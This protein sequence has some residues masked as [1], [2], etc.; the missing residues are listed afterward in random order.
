MAN[1][2]DDEITVAL[3]A[4]ATQLQEGMAQAS[5]SITNMQATVASEAA[6][7]NAAVQT[8]IDA[9]VRLNAAFSSNVAS[10]EGIAEAEAALDQAMNAGAITAGEYASYV[11]TLDAAE[12]ALTTTAQAASAALVEQNAAM[13]ISG[14]VARELGVMIGELARGNYTRLEGST[15]TLANRTGLL[16]TALNAV[17]SPLGLVA[18]AAAAVGYSIFEAGEDFEKMEGTVLATGEAAGFTAGQL[19]GIAD[20]IGES[21]G[22]ISNA[23][24][25]VQKLALSGRFAGQD[26]Q[27]VATAAADMSQLTGESIQSCITQIE[28]L[29]EDPLKA[30]A[31]LNDQ[32]HFLTVAQFEQMESLAQS[33]DIMGAA[34]IAYAAMADKMQGRSDEA[35]QHVNILVKSLRELKTVWAEDMQELDHALGGG[36]D[37]YGLNEAKQLLATLKEQQKYAEET[38]SSALPGITAQ[39]QRQQ[40]IVDQLT[41]GFQGQAN[42]AKEVGKAAQDSANKIDEMLKN[43][44]ETREDSEA[45]QADRERYEQMEID[46][47][48]SLQQEKDYWTQIKN[49]AKEGSAEYRQAL[50]QLVE[51]HRKEGQ[52]AKEAARQS[53]E[54][55][56]QASAATM[57]DLEVQRE[58]TQTA[59]QARIQIDE[60]IVQNAE[61]LYGEDSAQYKRAVAEKISDTKSFAAA[62]I[63]EAKKAQEFI[64]SVYKAQTDTAIKAVDEIYASRQ[65]EV[66]SELTLGQI[67]AA[68]QAE[69]LREY[70]NQEY[71]TD[72][73]ILEHYRDLMADKPDIVQKINDQIVALQLKRAATMQE[74]DQK[75]A[76]DA[77]ESWEQSLRPI[78]Q[79]FDQSITGMI[80]GTQ[81][82]H[83]AWDRM[84]ESM[85]MSEIR[86]GAQTLTH[87]ISTE[88]AKTSA[89]V[90]GAEA[91]TSAQAAAAHEG[92]ATEAATQQQEIMNAAS[93]AAAKAYQAVV[94]IPIVGPVLAPVAA[95]GAFAAVEAYD[96]ISSAS[97]G[98]DRVPFDDAPA[99]L[100]RNEMVLPAHLA[101]RVRGMTDGSGGGGGDTHQWNIS[102]TDA[103]SFRQMML[104]DPHGFAKAA[105]RAVSKTR[106]RR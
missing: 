29:Q 46:R 71:Q 73:D 97:G 31:K 102:A 91:R 33:G 6:A 106:R 22:S 63:E 65:K 25:A 93:T 87:W 40:Q 85:L 27:L 66:Q 96:T 84:L 89:T 77:Q 5:A 37:A 95:A 78:M 49:E 26:L 75:A 34:S 62:Q 68:Q 4:N 1:S 11:A 83:Q 101:D 8:K 104:S 81:T 24:E 51:V 52:A 50:E 53:V 21:T 79:A 38:G 35:N 70:A 32:F 98:W 105:Q 56:K 12:A 30:V 72:L 9:M 88:L 17:L 23:T 42:A 67:S 59:S 82:F 57:N 14:G 60:Q 92:M 74:I 90:A 19:V 47:N 55:R 13:T 39:I 10:T 16:S 41:K 100:H 28:K 103:K 61:K 69:L 2:Y 54:A 64:D 36:D 80:Q 45:T 48:L 20:R 15:I 99:L 94:G 76:R 18:V 86:T 3:T 43:M 44:E 58:E 7:F